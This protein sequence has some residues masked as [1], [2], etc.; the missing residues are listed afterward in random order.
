[1]TLGP[2]LWGLVAEAG[3]DRARIVEALRE[4]NGGESPD[5][6]GRAPLL[7]LRLEAS[8]AA[9]GGIAGGAPGPVQLLDDAAGLSELLRRLG[10]EGQ[11]GGDAGEGD[12]GADGGAEAEHVSKDGSGGGS[13]H[14]GEEGLG[15]GDRKLHSRIREARADWLEA[16]GD[17]EARTM[18]WTRERQEADTRL[19]TYRDRARELRERLTGL[20][21]QG[22]Q[23]P[24]PTCARPLAEAHP[25]LVQ[26]LQEEWETVVQDGKW[27]K[28]RRE[29]LE[30]R[31]EDLRELERQALRL[32]ARVESL[33][34]GVE[35]EDPEALGTL[36]VASTPGI[37]GEALTPEGADLPLRVSRTFLRAA[38]EFLRRISEGEIQGVSQE[39]GQDGDQRMAVGEARLRLLREGGEASIPGP[40]EA[41][42]LAS[43]LLLAGLR[44]SVP[45][46]WDRVGLMTA[47]S[48]AE[49]DL[50]AV[51]TLEIMADESLPWPI[52]VVLPP[53]LLTR[54]PELFQGTVELLR[55]EDGRPRFRA[56]P[57]GVAWIHLPTVREDS[58]AG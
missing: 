37:H 35:E 58:L 18:E 31:P 23:A 17:L 33:S 4:R 45:V 44:R 11:G 34:E 7:R 41:A 30:D 52:L 56:S 39:V 50:R 55:D 57:G 51:R 49:G 14:R 40:G 10:E 48:G 8:V 20:E 19:Q 21:A 1:V 46:G 15:G 12:H 36:G 9:S 54:C 26:L 28:R 16:A 2:G 5:P 43:A 13:G 29:Q 38:G 42:F 53:A 47:L 32:H 6:G 3:A 25:H 22:A 24:C 27:W